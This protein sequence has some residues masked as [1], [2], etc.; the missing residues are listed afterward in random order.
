M[1]EGKVILKRFRMFSRSTIVMVKPKLIF[2]K[3]RQ[4]SNP[5]D[6]QTNIAQIWLKLSSDKVTWVHLP[7]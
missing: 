5:T 6:I 3:K 4:T 7:F 1:W 2:I